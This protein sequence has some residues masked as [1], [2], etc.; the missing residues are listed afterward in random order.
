MLQPPHQHQDG[1]VFPSAAAVDTVLPPFQPNSAVGLCTSCISSDAITCMRTISRFLAKSTR[2]LRHFTM[3]QATLQLFETIRSFQL[4]VNRQDSNAW[5][6][7]IY[8]LQA[9]ALRTLL[10]VSFPISSS[11]STFPF[12]TRHLCASAHCCEVILYLSDLA[13]PPGVELLLQHL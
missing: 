6:R 2:R 3:N 8:F 10:P 12:S 9:S 13:P 11:V 7:L 4:V 1:D 5:I